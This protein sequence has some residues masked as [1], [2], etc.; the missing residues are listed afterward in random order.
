MITGLLIAVTSTLLVS[1]TAAIR[2]GT[3]TGGLLAQ[4]IPET[5]IQQIFADPRIEVYPPPVVSTS[6]AAARKVNWKQ[7]KKTLLKKDSVARGKAFISA[8]RSDFANATAQYGVSKESLTAVMR[9]ETNLG[10]FTGRTPVFNVFASGV[11]NASKARWNVQARNLTALVRYCYENNIDC[12]NL[13]GS[14]AGAFGLSQ[15]LPHSVVT[16]GVDGDKDGTIDLFNPK[17]VIPTTANFLKVH[18]WG[19]TTASRKK[20]LAAYYGSSK[21]YPDVTLSYGEALKR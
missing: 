19:T 13:K 18:G 15:F 2:L 12:L 3:V 9:I 7:I 11:I 14:Y 16:W 6:T 4:Q 21:G 20:A 8:N 1:P 10:L 17:D 5:Y